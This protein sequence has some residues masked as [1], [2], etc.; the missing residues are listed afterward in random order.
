MHFTYLHS[1][2][3]TT[4]FLFGCYKTFRDAEVHIKEVFGNSAE[5]DHVEIDPYQLDDDGDEFNCCTLEY[6]EYH[7]VYT[8]EPKDLPQWVKK[9]WLESCIKECMAKTTIVVVYGNPKEMKK[10][11][12]IVRNC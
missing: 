9:M 11:Y 12:D 2:D 10:V 7:V 4:P 5:I 1:C 8:V 3:Q 6:D